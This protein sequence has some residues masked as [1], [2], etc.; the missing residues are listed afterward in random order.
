MRVAGQSPTS[1]PLIQTLFV[2]ALLAVGCAPRPESKESAPAP[3]PADSAAAP[4]PAPAETAPVADLSIEGPKWTLTR[5]GDR[6][7]L[8]GMDPP[9]PPSFTLDAKSKRVRGFAGCNTMTGSY[10]LDG[11]TLRFSAMAVTRMFCTHRME[12]EAAFL[13]ALAA[14]TTFAIAQGELTLADSTGAKL[15]LLKPAP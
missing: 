7:F 14:T 10:E 2:C 11:A 3:F 5:V 15:A 8:P 9:A 6:A 12:V 4:L 1:P 13:A